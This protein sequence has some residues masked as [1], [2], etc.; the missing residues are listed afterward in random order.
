MANKKT[1]KKVKKEEVCETFEVE[2]EG[3]EKLKT[4]CGSMEKKTASKEELKK[5]DKILRNVLIGLGVIII[6]VITGYFYIS[7]LR[8]F[9]YR[10]VEGEIVSEGDLIFYQISVPYQVVNNNV[11]PYNV[12]IRNDPRKLDKIPFEGEM[13]FGRRFN[14]FLYRLVINVNDTFDCEGDGIISIANMANLQS[15][16]V[17]VMSDK[18]ATC[19]PSGRYMYANIRLGEEDKIT[20]IG[21]SCYDL[22]VKECDILKVTE[23]FMV[24]M[25]VRYFEEKNN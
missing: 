12:Y 13:D 11:I 24:E 7:S 21:P 19:D 25:F 4:V 22:Q 15:I 14:D 23:R 8:Y 1:K 20:E 10:G 16:R 3:K 5:Q 2:K 17:K 6:L 18:N 9:E